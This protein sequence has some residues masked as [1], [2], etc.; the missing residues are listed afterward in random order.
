M[1][2]PAGPWLT[3][4]LSSTRTDL[5][6]QHERIPYPT[7][8]TNRKSL[9]WLKPKTE[10]MEAARHDG[11]L[12]R[13]KTTICI[14]PDKQLAGGKRSGAV[15]EGR[16]GG[17]K[18]LASI[19]H[20]PGW[21]DLLSEIRLVYFKSSRGIILRC[22]TGM[23]K[24]QRVRESLEQFKSGKVHKGRTTLQ[25]QVFQ[26]G[27]ACCPIPSS[28][29]FN[30][31]NYNRQHSNF[32]NHSW[33]KAGGN[34]RDLNMRERKQISDIPARQKPVALKRHTISPG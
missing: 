4:G 28:F 26:A 5:A 11:W 34:K 32:L 10:T 31:H 29:I 19:S 7:P 8:S 18:Q 33:H 16:P 3:P 14:L 24:K 12:R 20:L 30:P 9:A 2:V 21:K 15:G 25:H 22:L 23:R 1:D 17:W 27:C 6:E 13:L